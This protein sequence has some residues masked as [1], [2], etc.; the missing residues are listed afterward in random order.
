ME[1]KLFSFF[2]ILLCLGFISGCDSSQGNL[3][4]NVPVY[5]PHESNLGVKFLTTK[6]SDGI[7]L[8]SGDTVGFEITGG[9]FPFKLDNNSSIGSKLSDSSLDLPY[10][11]VTF[12]AG[13]NTS[14]Q[15][16]TENLSVSD[17]SGQGVKLSFKINNLFQLKNPLNQVIQGYR[18]KVGE[19]WGGVLPYTF[20]IISSGST[21]STVG[22]INDPKTGRADLVFNSGYLG[23]ETV[24]A[25]DSANH[26]QDWIITIDPMPPTSVHDLPQ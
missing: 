23:S 2:G 18:F 4:S 20:S 12:N 24:R 11:V 16:Y 19:L 10:P 21:R 1:R 26:S 25:T 15:T 17:S 22:I 6:G 8:N 13:N 3:I 5:S 7:E 14:D 9:Q